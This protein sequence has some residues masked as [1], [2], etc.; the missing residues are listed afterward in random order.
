MPDGDKFYWGVRGTGSRTLLNLVRSGAGLDVAADQGAKVV[1]E[2]LKRV[3]VQGVLR[4]GIDILVSA[5]PRVESD[6]SAPARPVALAQ[7]A[8]RRLRRTVGNDDAGAVALRA[9][10][11]T[12]KR[13]RSSGRSFTRTEVKREVAGTCTTSLLGRAVFDGTRCELMREVGRL[14]Q[15]QL[16]YERELAAGVT[17]RMAAN[18]DRVFEHGPDETIRSP[19]RRSQPKSFNLDQ[20]HAPIVSALQ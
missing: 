1:T 8:L 10:E 20:L 13:L 14:A 3:P 2:Q 4:D 15:Q 7:A 16:V 12:Y 18:F 11:N 17:E 5:L 6:A 19:R 9:L